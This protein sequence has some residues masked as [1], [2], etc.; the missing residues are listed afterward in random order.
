M[1][2]GICNETFQGWKIDD[3]FTYCA[4]IG[5]DAVEVAPFTLAKYVTDIPAAE[6]VR[7]KESA[8][9][10]GIAISGIHWVLLQTEGLYLTSPDAATRE[11]TARYFCDLVD[12]CADI[13]GRIIVVGSPKQRNIL[14][15][16]T[17]EQ[18]WT[19]ATEVLRPAVKS[20][21][22][23]D[24]TICFEPLSPE[25]TNFI[26]T[27]AEGVRFTQ[28][29]GSPNFKVILDVRAMSSEAIPVS[30]IIRESKGAF[31]YFH[32]NDA[33]MKG[34]GFGDVDFRPIATALKEVGYD[35]YVSVEV[36]KYEEGA[37]T[38]ATKSLEYLKDV[39]NAPAK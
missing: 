22:I 24:V 29:L 25:D 31:A 39:F 14:P 17:P 1:K 32:A 6:R 13:G 18:A 20:A 15:G 34:P 3:I 33:N 12:F 26:N 11:R 30:Q 10:A 19:W 28:Q 27:A 7:I 9:R 21:E 16:V 38:I 37:E 36:F 23:R 35:G 5:Y 4:R 8:A 2:F